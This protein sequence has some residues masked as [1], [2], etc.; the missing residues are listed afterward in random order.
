MTPYEHEETI[1]PGTEKS[2][3]GK[4]PFTSD[5]D[6]SYCAGNDML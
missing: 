2:I 5:I 1:F 6:I 4:I 3:L